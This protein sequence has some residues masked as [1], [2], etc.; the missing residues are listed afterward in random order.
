MHNDDSAVKARI[1]HKSF[2][3]P[4]ILYKLELPSQETCLA[5]VSSHHDHKLGEY[6]GIVP[7]VEN[8]VVFPSKAPMYIAGEDVSQH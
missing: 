2:R 4:N 1:L 8:L 6:I 7:E 5:L 3:G